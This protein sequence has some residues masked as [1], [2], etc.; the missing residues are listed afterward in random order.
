MFGG[1]NR[2]ASERFAATLP[3]LSAESSFQNNVMMM[4]RHR[5]R[6]DDNDND[7]DDD[8]GDEP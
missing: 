8:D 3:S 1:S 6:L 5:R 7:D 4:V 2:S